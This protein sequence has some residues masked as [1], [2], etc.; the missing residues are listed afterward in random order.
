[1]K[2]KPRLNDAEIRRRYREILE[3]PKLSD[4]QIECLRSHV[5]L[6][7]Q[8]ICEQVWGKKVY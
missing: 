8:A 6:L 3:R 7:A 1:M 4:Q 2:R 5:R